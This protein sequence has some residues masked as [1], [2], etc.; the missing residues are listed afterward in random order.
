MVIND[1]EKYIKKRTIDHSVPQIRVLF[2]KIKEEEI[3]KYPDRNFILRAVG[4]EWE[5]TM[6][7]LF[8]SINQSECRAFCG[9]EFESGEA[10]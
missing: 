9:I 8:P 1:W 5:K 10:E 7:E 6:F 4:A 2:G 3:R